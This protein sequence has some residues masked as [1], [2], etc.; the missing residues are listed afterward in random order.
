[1]QLINYL[2]E[3]SFYFSIEKQLSDSFNYVYP[4]IINKGI[5]SPHYI[6]VVFSSCTQIESILKGLADNLKIDYLSSKK[7]RDIWKF[8]DHGKKV[9]MSCLDKKSNKVN[10]FDLPNRKILF[11]GNDSTRWMFEPWCFLIDPEINVPEWWNGYNSLKHSYANNF[12]RGTLD[13]ALSCTAALGSI[14]VFMEYLY[15]V[16]NSRGPYYFPSELFMVEGIAR[17]KIGGSEF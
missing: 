4:S 14:L 2:K 5:I 7:S 16:E 8:D 13:L 12:N 1:M 6:N 10:I 3:W 15:K 17:G 9:L 11:L